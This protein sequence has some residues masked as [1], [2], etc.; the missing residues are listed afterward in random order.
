MLPT[1]KNHN[2]LEFIAMVKFYSVSG[3]EIECKDEEFKLNDVIFP[4]EYNPHNVRP[5]VITSLYGV[6]GVV[7]GSCEQ[8]ALDALCD[9]GLSNAFLVD[10]ET[11]ETAGLGNA[12]EPH[13]LTNCHIENVRLD[14][15]QDCRLIA[16]I[17]EQRGA[18]ADS[19]SC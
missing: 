1:A 3:N 8:D 15:K 7:W 5:W 11:E 14:E 18:R 13:D 12:S 19:L 17:A 10:E 9:E 16:K 4:W 6:C 2:S